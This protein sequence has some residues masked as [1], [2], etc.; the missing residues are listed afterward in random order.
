[1]IPWRKWKPEY[2]LCRDLQHAWS[3]SGAVRGANGFIR[4]MECG[5]CRAQKYQHLDKNGF[6]IRTVMRYPEGYINAGN[7]RMSRA[8][9]AE[10]RLGQLGDHDA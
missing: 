2:L 3:P 1:M 10:L 5:R 6:I 4:A 7:G 8:D 9:R